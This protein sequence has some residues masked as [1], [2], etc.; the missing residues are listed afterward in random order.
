MAARKKPAT[1]LEVPTQAPAEH[2]HASLDSH[3]LSIQGFLDLLG[4]APEWEIKLDEVLGYELHVVRDGGLIVYNG[5]KVS[6]LNQ[7]PFISVAF[8]LEVNRICAKPEV[9]RRR[10]FARDSNF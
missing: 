7:N 6:W 8:I 10:R 2:P 5:P 4:K 1:T 3:D 9:A